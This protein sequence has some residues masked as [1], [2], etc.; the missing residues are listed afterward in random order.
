MPT[1]VL[2]FFFYSSYSFNVIVFSS[3]VTCYANDLVEAHKQNC[4][5]VIEWVHSFKCYGTT[6]TMQALNV[7]IILF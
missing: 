1:Q 4:T 7:F 2:L 6:S 3:E 5:R